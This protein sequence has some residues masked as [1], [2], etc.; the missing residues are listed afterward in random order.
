MGVIVLAMASPCLL[1]VSVSVLNLSI[2]VVYLYEVPLA[3]KSTCSENRL[4]AGSQKL[5]GG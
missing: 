1:L 5:E 4:K 3:L 2:A